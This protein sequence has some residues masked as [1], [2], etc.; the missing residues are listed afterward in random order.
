MTKVPNRAMRL[1]LTMVL[2]ACAAGF[3]TRREFYDEALAN[4][5]FG[6]A[7]ASLLIL[8]LRVRPKWA[9]ALLVA[10]CVLA[11]ALVDFKILHYPPHLA[12]WASFAGVSSLLV[13][14][15]RAV[16]APDHD[17]RILLYAWIPAVLFMASE[18][19]GSDLLDW[20]TAAHPKTLDM[21]LL[22]FDA[23]LRVQLSFVMGQVFALWP[24]LRFVAL[25]FY[26]GL[27]VP[28]ILVYAGRLVKFGTKAF[29]VMLAFLVTGPLGIL[30]Y[31]LFPACGPIHLAGRFFPFNPLSVEQ[32]GHLFLE[33]VPIVGFRN[34]MP[35]LHLAWT[36][37]AWWA[38]RGLSWWERSIVFIF[39]AMTIVATLGTGEHYLVDLV[40]A[41][42]FALMVLA[43]C[44]YQVSWRDSH[45]VR[46]FL[47]GL[48]VT[49]AWLV[50]LR[51][52]NRLFWTSPV[53]SWALVIATVA[54]T[55][56]R[57]H[58]FD[59]SLSGTIGGLERGPSKPASVTQLTALQS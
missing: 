7:L 33:A 22:S 51:Y 31:N 24:W 56:I 38:S 27:P 1:A 18:W 30:F 44:A 21:Y 39:F 47:F 28:I 29:S 36:L 4:A 12:A 23:S 15:T 41:Y 26:V 3:A 42:P 13:F 48:V 8:H 52:A 2:A 50:A 37:L 16:W 17:R 57:Q 34:A 53:V 19:F 46:A 5:F 35:S 59:R 58:E 10:P 11:L 14:G 45:R 40:V 49:V 6:V 32:A 9:D 54:L 25:V 55:S 43:G 20:T